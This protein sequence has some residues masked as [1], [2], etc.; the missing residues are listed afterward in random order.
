MQRTVSQSNLSITAPLCLMCE[1]LIWLLYTL[2]YW[3]QHSHALFLIRKPAFLL[4]QAYL[5]ISV[6]TLLVDR[7]RTEISIQ[8]SRT[9]CAKHNLS[10]GWSGCTKAV[11]TRRRDVGCVIWPCKSLFKRRHSSVIKALSRW[12]WWMRRTS[13]KLST[14]KTFPDNLCSPR[15]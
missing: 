5:S 11:V 13:V 2:W 10:E 15:R 3:K 9:P 7:A 8:T 12:K 14:F 1:Q 4:V 6:R